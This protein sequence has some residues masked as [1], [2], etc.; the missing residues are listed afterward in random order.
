MIIKTVY[1]A[2]PKAHYDTEFEME[3]VG[4]IFDMLIPIGSDVMDEH[5][6]IFN[7]NQKILSA[8]YKARKEAGDRDP[9][10]LFREY[11]RA[12]D[13]VV[14]VSFFDGTIGA[15]VAEELTEALEN[16]KEVYIIYV[17]NMR[18][19]FMPVVSM[20]HYKTL[21]IAET[22]DKTMKEEM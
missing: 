20:T 16:D 7:P 22:R 10:A 6:Q 13:I 18:K 8:I 3:C 2:H 5:I 21:S 15:G 9:F 17:S 11:A 14:G 12:A 4:L 1:F 19:V